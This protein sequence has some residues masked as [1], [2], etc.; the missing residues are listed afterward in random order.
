MSVGANLVPSDATAVRRSAGATSGECDWRLPSGEGLVAFA[1]ATGFAAGPLAEP[2]M[3]A[4]R[5]GLET[6]GLTSR[7]DHQRRS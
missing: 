4:G 3:D 6:V 7:R 1:L 5:P 2:T